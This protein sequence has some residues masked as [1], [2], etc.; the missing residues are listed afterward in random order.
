MQK[1]ITKSHPAKR[2]DVAA[3]EQEQREYEDMVS[4]SRR[5]STK[6]KQMTRVAQNLLNEIGYLL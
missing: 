5:A 4:K 2:I 1:R 6:A 3:R